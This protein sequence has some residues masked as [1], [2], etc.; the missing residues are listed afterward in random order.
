MLRRS[1]LV[2]E[3]D[4]NL[5]VGARVRLGDVVT[6]HSVAGQ[7]DALRER[8]DRLLEDSRAALLR[9]EIPELPAEPETDGRTEPA[10]DED[11]NAGT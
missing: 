6:D 4:P 1:G 9:D 7:L 2:Q 3:V 8:V 5:Y 11:E 10:Q